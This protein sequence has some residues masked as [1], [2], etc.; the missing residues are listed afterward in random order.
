[1]APARAIRQHK[2]VLVFAVLKPIKDPL[3]L[4]QSAHEVEIRLPVLNA[5]VPLLVGAGETL[6]VLHLL[7]VKHLLHN[8]DRRLALKDPALPHVRQPL[9]SRREPSAILRPFAN[10]ADQSDAREDAVNLP[11]QAIRS[12]ETEKSVLP[13]QVLQDQRFIDL[14]EELDFEFVWLR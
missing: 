1:D 3:V 2:R 14:G 4:E 7:G 10:H 6:S 9:E 5:E 12:P 13:Q 8:L 11:L